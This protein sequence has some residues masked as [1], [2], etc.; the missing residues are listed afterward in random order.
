MIIEFLPPRV[1]PLLLGMTEA[2]ARD[3]LASLGTVK[4][5]GRAG[6]CYAIN[7]ELGLMT[8]VIIVGD[9]VVW[10]ASGPTR[11]SG[12]VHVFRGIDVY[13][14]YRDVLRALLVLGVPILSDR[15]HWHF[16]VKDLGLT[17]GISGPDAVVFEGV[18]LAAPSQ[19][20]LA[21]DADQPF[22]LTDLAALP[23]YDP[24]DDQE[25]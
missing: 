10:I 3:A 13:Q 20:P 14:P 6:D 12:P 24:H 22:T 11:A 21:T 23:H 4:D 16:A 18:G 2:S 5:G 15:L 19:Y 9:E 17:M 1:G 8:N 25:D 7:H